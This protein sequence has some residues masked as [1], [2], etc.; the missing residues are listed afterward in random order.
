MA[1]SLDNDNDDIGETKPLLQQSPRSEQSSRLYEPLGGSGY[2]LAVL[3]LAFFIEGADLGSFPAVFKVLEEDLGLSPS[4]LANIVMC[5]KVVAAVSILAWGMLADHYPKFRL[6]CFASALW[7]VVAL[8]MAMVSTIL[9]LI[10]VRLVVGMCAGCLTPISQVLVVEMMPV[11]H[12]GKAFGLMLFCGHLG[13]LIGSVMATSTEHVLIFGLEGWRFCYVVIAAIC[14]VFFSLAMVCSFVEPAPTHNRDRVSVSFSSFY[15]VLGV[16]TIQVILLQGVFRNGS[17]SVLA[18]T[19]MWVQYLG[20]N[21]ITASFVAGART[22]GWMVGCVFAG[23]AS[24][25]VSRKA[26]DYGRIIFGQSG[27]FLRVTTTILAFAIFPSL[28]PGTG[29][30]SMFSIGIS[31]FVLGFVQPWAFVGVERPLLAEVISRDMIG[32]AIAGAQI[33][34][35]LGGALIAGPLVSM[36]TARFGYHELNAGEHTD[37]SINAANAA[38][39]GSAIVWM[40]TICHIVMIGLISMLYCTYR[41]DRDRALALDAGTCKG[42]TEDDV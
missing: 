41:T 25:S 12:R 35:N 5:E 29:S 37:K 39:L 18:F 15:Y 27:D 17:I 7:V 11:H 10:M 36:M 30:M 22:V 32:A 24:D 13:S 42:S 38:A 1:D 31:L 28:L 26:P 2:I 9:Q 33:F 19:T 4:E 14:V 16:P 34:E 6:L 21:D 40:V 23:V 8:G 20:F 3:G